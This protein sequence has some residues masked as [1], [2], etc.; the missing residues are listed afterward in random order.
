M[1]SHCKLGTEVLKVHKFTDT[2]ELLQMFVLKTN[3]KK[4][5]FF[6]FIT[7]EAEI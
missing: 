2:N 1:V 3:K 6:W 7:L 5:I 4:Y